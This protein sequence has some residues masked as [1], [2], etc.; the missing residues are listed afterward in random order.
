MSGSG[1]PPTLRGNR[2]TLRPLSRTDVAALNA[3]VA[4]PGVREWWGTDPTVEEENAF[5][6]EVDGEIA[7]WLAFY[8]EDDPDYRHGGLDI[9]VA[10]RVPRPRARPRGA[11]PGRAVAARR[12]R[13]P[14]ADHRPRRGERARDQG[15]RGDRLQAGRHHAP[16]RTRARGR[17][18]RRTADGPAGRGVQPQLSRVPWP[19]A[20]ATRS[21]SRAS[22]IIS[23]FTSGRSSTSWASHASHV[24]PSRL[25]VSR[26]VARPADGT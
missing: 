21:P 10:P 9:F 19:S 15:L 26:N 6:I 7:G 11:Q 25:T 4:L 22:A 16:L 13:P 20:Q 14:P 24:A 18:A 12:A 1:D 3:M 23:L 8:E 5:T 17:L 2:V